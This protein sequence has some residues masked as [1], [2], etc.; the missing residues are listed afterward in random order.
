MLASIFGKVTASLGRTYVFSG[1]LPAGLLILTIISFLGSAQ[2]IDVQV[3]LADADSW[4]QWVWPAAIWISVGFL[5][6]VWRAPI[7]K[8]FQF[9]PT[10]RIGRRLLFGRI[11]QRERL[12]RQRIYFERRSSALYWLQEQGMERSKVGDLPA[13]LVRSL[14]SDEE[15]LRAST[16]GRTALVEVDRTVGDALSLTVTQSDKI[17]GG[18]FALYRLAAVHEHRPVLKMRIADE[19]DNW[20]TASLSGEA[21]DILELVDQ[22]NQRAIGRA[23]EN[24]QKFGDGPYVFPTAL[25]NQISALDDYGEKRYGID[26][27]TIW[28]R[29]WWVLPKDVKAEVSDSRL[30]LETLVNVMVSLVL[31]IV[32][33]WTLQINECGLVPLATGSCDATRAVAFSVSGLVLLFVVYRGA[34]FAMQ[35]LASK[36]TSLIDTYRLATL[37][38]LGFAPKTISEEKELHEGLRSLFTQAVRLKKDWKLQFKAEGSAKDEKKNEEK[39]AEEK[40]LGKDDVEE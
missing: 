39:K 28:D 2:S 21:K 3:A 17:A 38:Q 1:L 6:Y 15:L 27:A 18:I 19:M 10:G 7:F 4:K 20:R 11:A 14:P 31:A 16:I 25:G 37:S 12:R 34:C 40:K 33:I 5:F 32:A 13:W 35:V 8:V 23:F 24:C 36:M 26:T 30:A 22:D 29:M 9:S